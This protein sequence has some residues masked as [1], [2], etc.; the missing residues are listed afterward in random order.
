MLPRNTPSMHSDVD[1]MSKAH[2]YK[3]QFITPPE[4]DIACTDKIIERHSEIRCSSQSVSLPWKFMNK[5]S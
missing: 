1:V 3:I 5:E 2:F 4:S